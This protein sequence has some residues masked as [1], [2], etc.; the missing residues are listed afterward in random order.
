ML[1]LFPLFFATMFFFLLPSYL[2]QVCYQPSDSGDERVVLNINSPSFVIT[3]WVRTMLSVDKAPEFFRSPVDCFENGGEKKK[4]SQKCI[5]QN[6]RA[7]ARLACYLGIIES[8]SLK[9]NK[10]FRSQLSFFSPFNY[11]RV[12]WQFRTFRFARFFL[13]C[14]LPRQ[15]K[16]SPSPQ[17][18]STIITR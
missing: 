15:L 2:T 9:R 1:H 7:V 18:I 13:V 4:R 14:L 17:Q 5:K 11:R 16:V 3:T 6:G 8:K 12:C 10:T